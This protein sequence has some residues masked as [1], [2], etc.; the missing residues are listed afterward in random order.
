MTNQPAVKI[1]LH[2]VIYHWL[3]S[4]NDG[5]GEIEDGRRDTGPIILGSCV[6]WGFQGLLNIRLPT[7]Q[8]AIGTCGKLNCCSA[9]QDPTR[10]K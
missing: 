10:S 6:S 8:R 9:L 4:T 3:T 7:A 5:I 2:P 1:A